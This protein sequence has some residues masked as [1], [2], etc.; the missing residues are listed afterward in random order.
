MDVQI[1]EKEP[2]I[3]YAI[4]KCDF[5]FN[6]ITNC[7]L[8]WT[9]ILG[10]GVDGRPLEGLRQATQHEVETY[11]AEQMA[12]AEANKPRPTNN[13]DAPPADPG[14]FV[15]PGSSSVVTE[16]RTTQEFLRPTEVPPV[17][18]AAKKGAKK[19]AAKIKRERAKLA[20]AAPA[21]KSA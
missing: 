10:R 14:D 8:P 4:P 1:V 18:V 21:A 20:A 15:R 7:V 16:D 12:G 17:P 11:F 3:V 13:P 9:E 19:A 2:E 6:T 5:L